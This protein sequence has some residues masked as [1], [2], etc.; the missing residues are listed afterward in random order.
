MTRYSVVMP[1][2]KVYQVCISETDTG[3]A[4]C[5]EPS[6]DFLTPSP[7]GEKATA[8]QD[9]ARQSRTDDGTG[10]TSRRMIAG[11]SHPNFAEMSLLNDIVA[12]NDIEQKGSGVKVFV[13][14]MWVVLI[15]AA[16]IVMQR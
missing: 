13:S 15:V 12:F 7:P 5:P 1:R 4:R 8:S 11:Q 6:S 9:Q 10:D 3:R 2:K 16:V 14:D